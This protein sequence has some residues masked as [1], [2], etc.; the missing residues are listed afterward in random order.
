VEIGATLLERSGGRDRVR[1]FVTDT[2]IGI[3]KEAQ[4]KLFQPYVQAAIDTARRFGGT[5]LGLIICRRL[6]AMMEGEIAMESEP[7]K[8]TT[9]SLTVALPIADPRDLPK[10][11]SSIESAA[12]LV[13]SRRRAPTVE[14]ARAEGTL[15]LIAE[16]HPTNRSVLTRQL[17]LLGYASVA[18][19]DGREALGKWRAGGFAAIVTDCNMPEM[20]GYDLARAVRKAEAGGRRVPIIACTANALAE[21]SQK[22]TEAGMD[23]FVSKPVELEGLARVMERWLPLPSATDAAA[24]PFNPSSLAE[25]SGGDPAMEREILADFRAASRA[26]MVSLRQAMERRDIALVTKTS[27]RVKGACLT[28]GAAALAGV[29]ERIETAGR[30][31]SWNAIA[32]EQGALE[33]EFDKLEKWL[34]DKENIAHG[35]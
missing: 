16:D 18:A 28:V 24:A 5:G 33:R 22:C 7:G 14:A 1:F 3:A 31:N 32:S 15:V 17:N 11:E 35:N 29:C 21:E 8:G 4:E 2:G 23:D 19:Q 12:A 25:V 20:D 30:K 9:M 13:A 34:D 6:A 26:D 10:V 27:H